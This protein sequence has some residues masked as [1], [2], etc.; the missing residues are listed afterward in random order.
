MTVVAL[1]DDSALPQHLQP[2]AA[3]DDFWI[4]YPRRVAKK[5]ARKAWSKIPPRLH[6]AILTALV[7]WRPV[8]RAK[9]PEFL[10]HPAT[11]L[12]GERWEDELPAD[13]AHLSHL[14]APLPASGTETR[15]EIPAHVQRVLDGL[16]KSR[17]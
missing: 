6:V 8:W 3:F 13:A 11:W 9:D 1:F 14:P 12:N 4:L 10:P 7:A 2:V 17:S 16:R 15:A 5:D